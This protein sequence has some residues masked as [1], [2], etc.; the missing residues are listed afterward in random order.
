MPAKTEKGWGS[1]F[2]I[3]R[4]LTA[5]AIFVITIN[6]QAV[7]D[8]G[9]NVAQLQTQSQFIQGAIN[10]LE[11]KIDSA[12]SKDEAKRDRTR[13]DSEINRIRVQVDKNR[14]AIDTLR[15]PR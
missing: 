11:R 3:D 9:K 2:T 15:V 8:L 14:D 6:I 1:V 13:R 7:R 12:Y 10:R 5:V 4:I